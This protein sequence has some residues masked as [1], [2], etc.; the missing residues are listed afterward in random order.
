MALIFVDSE[1]TYENR[2]GLFL[3]IYMRKRWATM[4]SQ[5]GFRLRGV[6]S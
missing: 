3:F 4:L 5:H 1:P 6:Q 2:Q